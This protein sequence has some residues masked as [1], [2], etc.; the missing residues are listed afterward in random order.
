MRSA[1]VALVAVTLTLSPALLLSPALGAAKILKVPAAAA[2]TT[3]ASPEA[4]PPPPVVGGG[5]GT[6]AYEGQLLRLAEILGAMHY[7]RHLC[8]SGEGDQWRDQMAALLDT[9]QPDEPRRRRMVDRF[10]R[11]Y[12]SFRSVYRECTPAATLASDRYLQEGAR[13]AADITARY[14]K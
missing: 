2:A 14:G 6:P 12:E 3:A 4:S 8:N 10:N 1:P 11:G 9:E 5:A 7:L 13:I